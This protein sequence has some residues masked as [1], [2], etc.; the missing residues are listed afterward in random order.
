MKEA[1]NLS[2]DRLLMNE[3]YEKISTNS[4]LFRFVPG[5]KKFVTSRIQNAVTYKPATT[6]AVYFVL[7][8][9]LFHDVYLKI[10][11][12]LGLEIRNISENGHIFVFSWKE[13]PGP[14]TD[15]MSL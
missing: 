2:C 10:A 3:Y 8:L 1:V 7:T 5:K 13:N 15:S 14:V 6:H 12:R 11:I 9:K 4:F